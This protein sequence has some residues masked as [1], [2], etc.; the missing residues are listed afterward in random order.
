MH[1]WPPRES[2]PERENGT[3]PIGVISDSKLGPGHAGSAKSTLGRTSEMTPDGGG[4]TVFSAGL[5]SLGGLECTPF[6]PEIPHTGQNGQKSPQKGEN[7]PFC[8]FFIL[9]LYIF[10][11]VPVGAPKWCFFNPNMGMGLKNTIL[12][13]AVAL[14]K[15]L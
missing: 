10:F 5:D 3:P 8:T 15:K 4:C 13:L 6:S 12:G 11:L 2:Q 9:Y 1:S 7:P 14:R